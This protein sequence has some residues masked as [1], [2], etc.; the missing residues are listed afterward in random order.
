MLALRV[1]A[2]TRDGVA[3]TVVSAHTLLL[4]VHAV[5]LH[6][7]FWTEQ[8]LLHLNQGSGTR[9]VARH[10]T[11]VPNELKSARMFNQPHRTNHSVSA[12]LT[13]VGS[14]SVYQPHRSCLRSKSSKY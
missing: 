14:Q 9:L 8:G 4:T 12:I 1:D 3:R 7:T 13:S 6:R 2:G 11:V 10:Y 5:R